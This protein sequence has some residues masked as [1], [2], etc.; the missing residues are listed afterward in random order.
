MIYL[1]QCYLPTFCSNVLKDLYNNEHY[2]FCK[3]A[4]HFKLNPLRRKAS[5]PPSLTFGDKSF[6]ENYVCALKYHFYSHQQL[7]EIVIE[8]EIAFLL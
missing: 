8:Y 4:L 7:K 2:D 3:N 6:S 5:F 1:C